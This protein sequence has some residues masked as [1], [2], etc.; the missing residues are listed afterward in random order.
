MLDGGLV[1][2]PQ[3]DHLFLSLVDEQVQL[4]DVHFLLLPLLTHLLLNVLLLR[5]LVAQT[6]THHDGVDVMQTLLL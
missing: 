3:L 1:A 4:V 2:F 6:V 5:H